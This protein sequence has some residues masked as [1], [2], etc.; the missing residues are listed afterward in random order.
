MDGKKCLQLLLH[1][2]TVAMIFGKVVNIPMSFCLFTSH[3]ANFEFV[4]FFLTLEGRV[5]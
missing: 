3:P 5:I 2:Y 4:G 1:A